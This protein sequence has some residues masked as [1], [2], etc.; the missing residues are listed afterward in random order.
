MNERITVS[1]SEANRSFSRLL[2]Q[3]KG[4]AHIDITSHGETVAELRP[5]SGTVEAELLRRKAAWEKLRGRLEQQE[6][7]T[8]GP[9]TRAELY[10]RD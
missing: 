6:R 4:G 2:R 10:E 9:W 5:K 8:I 1:A 7:V 3:V